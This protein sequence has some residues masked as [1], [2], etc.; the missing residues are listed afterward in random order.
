MND[1][2][3]NRHRRLLWPGF[4]ALVVVAATGVA[5]ASPIT[6][7]TLRVS[8]PAKVHGNDSR[9]ISVTIA[10]AGRE[11]VLVL[12][13]SA[14]LR[15][16]GV[17]AEYVPYPGPPIDPWGG[18]TSSRRARRLRSCFAIRRTSAAYGVCRRNL[19]DHRDLRGAGESP[20]A[21]VARQPEPGMAR[22]RRKPAA[23][24]TVD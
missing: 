2:A 21:A 5:A 16:E 13:N 20:A 8:A 19:P 23:T 3:V 22:P 10:N 6:P 12:P 4:V 1:C 24:M 9:D 17:G 7:L 11:P 15:I 14:R 18:R